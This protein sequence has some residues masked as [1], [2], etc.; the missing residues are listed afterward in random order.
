MT[1]SAFPTVSEALDS[2]TAKAQNNDLI[3]ITGSIF[4]IADALQQVES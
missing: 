2:A 4:L 3:L 1:G